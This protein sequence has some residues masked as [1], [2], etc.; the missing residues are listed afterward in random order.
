MWHVYDPASGVTHD[1]HFCHTLWVKAVIKI[2]PSLKGVDSNLTTE[3]EEHQCH[4]IGRAWWMG[5]I[6]AVVFGKYN[7]PVG[8]LGK[9]VD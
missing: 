6:L 4:M 2:Y 5:D 9:A 8:T 3:R 7:L 1:H